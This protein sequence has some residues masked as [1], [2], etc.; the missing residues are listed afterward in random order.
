MC[1]ESTRWEELQAGA[2]FGQEMWGGTLTLSL[3][4]PGRRCQGSVG[5]MGRLQVRAVYG[6]DTPVWHIAAPGGG[7]GTMGLPGSPTSS[8]QRD[9]PTGKSHRK[10]AW[11]S[12]QSETAATKHKCSWIWLLGSGAGPC[13]AFSDGI[14]WRG[15]R[16]AALEEVESI[17]AQCPPP[18]CAQA[19]APPRKK[20][21]S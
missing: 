5:Q 17:G 13:R 15:T 11:R 18:S 10:N 14:W 9:L 16:A 3:P 6:Q 4:C 21:L 12:Q 7:T 1:G 20:C 2:G 19:P 8:L